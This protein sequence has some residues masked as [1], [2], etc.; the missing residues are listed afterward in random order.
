MHRL[1]QLPHDGQAEPG[2]AAARR[3]GLFDLVEALPDPRL[4]LPGNTRAG[5]L[6]GEAQVLAHRCDAERDPPARWR[7]AHR[8]LEQIGEHLHEA[9]G[10]GGHR[11]QPGRRRHRQLNAAALQ[12]PLQL[13]HRPRPGLGGVHRHHAQGHLPGVQARQVEQILDQAVEAQ[14]VVEHHAHVAALLVGADDALLHQLEVA[15]Q[16]GERGAELV[17]DAGHQLAAGALQLLLLAQGARHL[18]DRLVEDLH[19]LPELARR[20]ALDP[21]AEVAAADAAGNLG[22]RLQ[23]RGDAAGERPGQ[24]RGG[25]EGDQGRQGEQ[26]PDVGQRL[27][28]LAGRDEGHQQ[29]AGNRERVEGEE[30]SHLPTAAAGVGLEVGDGLT[31]ADQAVELPLAQAAGE[32]RYLLEGTRDPGRLLRRGA[33]GLPRGGV[34]G[35]GS[36]AQRTAC[37]RHHL[38]GGQ[39]PA[40]AQDAEHAGGEDDAP[41]GL[42]DH[43]GTGQGHTVGRPRRLQGARGQQ[44]QLLVT[45]LLGVGANHQGQGHRQ[46]DQRDQGGEDIGEVEPP[47]ETERAP[48]H[49]CT[50]NL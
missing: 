46:H 12:L 23:R 39:A 24:Q 10:V 3:P 22:H 36:R 19:H 17:G 38:S 7:E 13:V 32:I 28:E 41:P 37:G 50:S 43:Q 25:G 18:V 27:V 9:V 34:G 48:L 4:L 11:R 30:H 6:H 16:G 29:P 14:G 45:L 33:A 26:A 42:S 40:G 5:V 8:I 21:A 1:Y 31:L 49:V 2:A 20:L 35:G 44:A 15:A 47:E